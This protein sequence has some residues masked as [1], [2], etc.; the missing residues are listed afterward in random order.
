MMN[1]LQGL[2]PN[3]QLEIIS[4]QCKL[5]FKDKSRFKTPEALII[6]EQ[7]LMTEESLKALLEQK[8]YFMQLYTPKVQ[9]LSNDIIEFFRDQNVVPISFSLIDNEITIG[10]LPE[11]I[12]DFIRPYKQTKVKKLP[13]PLYWFVT[14]WIKLYGLPDYLYPI[15]EKDLFN[16]I[17]AEAISLNAIDITIATQQNGA[18]V[19]FNVKKRKV[20]SKR[21]ITKE[22][23]RKIS[24][25]I[26]TLAQSP[27]VEEDK[28]PKYISINLDTHHRGRVVINNSYWGDVI[29]IRVLSNKML[30]TS[31]EDLNIDEQT[32]W[33]FRNRFATIEPG[34]RLICGAT[35][36][37]KNTTILS[38]LQELLKCDIY[39]AV[40]VESPVEILMD[41]IIQLPAETEEGFKLQVDSLIRQNP[42]LVYISEI[43][44]WTAKST[45]RLANTGK[46]VFSTI[47]CN[48]C[49]DA[50]TRLVDITGE[51]PTRILQNLHSIVFQKLVYEEQTDSIRPY[52]TYIEITQEMKQQLMR[53]NVQDIYIYLNRLENIQKV[54]RRSLGIWTDKI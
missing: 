24:S 30:K 39:K 10:I 21:V 23:V 46:P 47:H 2:I 20:K 8:E 29:T 35:A 32:R 52:C 54:E 42:D 37:G 40:S 49:A 6:Y 36:S 22:V 28:T 19:F 41:K 33:F 45:L 14:N 7:Q 51:S 25:L 43:T 16:I 27:L 13:V 4:N 18:D 26:S 48:S 12:K 1:S 3:T 53:S 15:P 34:L 31:L 38:A 5:R 50:I 9:Y 11:N 44:A 17:I